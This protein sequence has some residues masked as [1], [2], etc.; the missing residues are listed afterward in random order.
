VRWDFID[1]PRS[2]DDHARTSVVD[3]IE[4]WWEAFHAASAAI[5]DRFAKGTDF[6]IVAFMHEHLASVSADLCWEYGPALK[7]SGHRLVV[8]AESRKV[9]RPLVRTLLTLAPELPRWEFYGYRLPEPDMV[10]RMIESRTGRPARGLRGRAAPGRH[11]RI[12]L[13]FSCPGLDHA[14]LGSAAFVATETLLGEEVLDTWVGAIEAAQEEAGEW[15]EMGALAREVDRIREQILAEV[16]NRPCHAIREEARW[17]RV[18]IEPRHAEDYARRRDIFVATTMQIELF[19]T[20]WEEALFSSSRFSRVGEIFCYIKM[21]GDGEPAEAREQS[22]ARI[23]NAIQAALV[24]AKLG[25]CIGGATGLRYS[26]IDLALMDVT[27]AAELVRRVLV[28]AGVSRRSWILFFDDMWRDEWIG[29]SEETPPPP[30][31]DA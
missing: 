20:A 29:L 2:E 27:R 23:A 18:K 25:C 28:D 31:P 8:T 10:H 9:L 6:D 12:D 21:D 24:P 16:P 30:A 1:P 3:A 22:W 26:Y 17:S 14:E 5:D 7:K 15:L 11:H 13:T 19:R 4:R